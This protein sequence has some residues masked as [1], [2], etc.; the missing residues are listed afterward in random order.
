MSIYL[1]DKKYDGTLERVVALAL[2]H[3]LIP[4]PSDYDDA[5]RFLHPEKGIDAIVESV[6]RNYPDNALA[7][8]NP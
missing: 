3:H 4:Q 5:F 2:D 1:A 8:V 7:L 6:V